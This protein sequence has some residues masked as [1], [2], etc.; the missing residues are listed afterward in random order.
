MPA[1]KAGVPLAEEIS[2]QSSTSA[3]AEESLQK[4]IQRINPHSRLSKSLPSP[5]ITFPLPPSYTIPL[6]SFL[7]SLGRAKNVA[8][9]S[10]D[11]VIIGSGP[12][13][14]SP[15]F[16]PASLV[17]KSPVSNAPNS[18]ASVSNWGCIP[19]KTLIHDAHFFHEMLNTGPQIRPASRQS[20]TPVEQI[21]ERSRN[22]RRP[23]FQG[24][25]LPL[26]KEQVTHVIGNA[27]IPE[28]R[29]RGSQMRRAKSADNSKHLPS[30]ILVCTGAR[31]KE[32][33]QPEVDGKKVL[34]SREAMILSEVPKRL[35]I[36]GAGG[37]RREFALHLSGIRSQITLIEMLP[38]ILP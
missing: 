33:S 36:I 7:L 9:S 37:H 5:R 25:R 29:R 24:H 22:V 2:L 30:L 34:G 31:N 26:Q 3:L 38:K 20:Q 21:V 10:Y 27:F 32:A 6:F 15:P 17:K 8:E 35:C 1:A 4:T 12:A 14:M 18:A 19:T 13:V 16:A 23:A 28:G 11:V